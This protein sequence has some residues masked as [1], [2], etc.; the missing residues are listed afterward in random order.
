MGFEIVFTK[1]FEW[2][3]IIW[4]WTMVDEYERGVRLRNGSNTA[5]YYRAKLKHLKIY[6]VKIPYWGLE[7]YEQQFQVVTGLVWKVPYF[8]RIL[9]VL[10]TPTT[11]N[12]NEQSVTT[13]DWKGVVLKTSIKYEIK[14]VHKQLLK[15]NDAKD[16]MSDMFK[17]IVR[18]HFAKRN[19]DQCNGEEITDAITAD[20]KKE[21]RKWGVNVMEFNI[22]DIQVARTIRLF[23]TNSTSVEE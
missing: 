11:M 15:V 9:T 23:N 10:I 12:L 19:W 6:G 17:G 16:A 4:P 1:L 13:L 8:D 3:E 20:V 22:T 2:L 14:D 18:S 21:G 5:T 7:K